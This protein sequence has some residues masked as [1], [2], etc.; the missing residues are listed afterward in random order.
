[1]PITG[2]GNDVIMDAEG[3]NKLKFGVGIDRTMV[4]VVPYGMDLVVKIGNGGE[5]VRIV[6]WFKDGA[7]KLSEI[8][9]ADG[10]TWGKTD[11]D[12]KIRLL[13]GTEGAD[14]LDGSAMADL[15]LGEDGDDTI[16]GKEGDDSLIGG[17]G[18]DTLQ[19]GAGDDSYIWNPGDGN[20]TLHD[21]DGANVLQIGDGIDPSRVEVRRDGDSLVLVF[22]QTGEKLDFT[23]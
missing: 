16:D 1:M 5:S 17:K 13:R 10:T 19:G 14:T 18:N 4:K 21:V 15:L 20:D 6:D 2:D 12:G 9:F 23:D 22:L 7:N 11:I 3:R 8:L